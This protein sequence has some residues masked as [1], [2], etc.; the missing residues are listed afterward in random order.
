[1]CHSVITDAATPMGCMFE[2]A[3]KRVYHAYM[4]CN[5]IDGYFYASA[6][7]TVF[8]AMDNGGSTFNMALT[9]GTAIDVHNNNDVVLDVACAVSVGL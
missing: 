2:T 7:A 9:Y 4:A 1:M 6:E 5:D 3:S 8:T